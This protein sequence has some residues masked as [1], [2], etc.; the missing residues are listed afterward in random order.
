[1]DARRRKARA[2]RLTHSQFFANLRQR[3]EPGD[4]AFDDPSFGQDDEALGVVRTFD[5]FQADAGQRSLHS[6][7]KLGSADIPHRRRASAETDEGPQGR[8][9]QDAAVAVLNV[10]GV[11]DGV[12]QQALRVDV[13]YGVLAVDLLAR[14]IAMRDPCLSPSFLLLSRSALLKIAA[15]GVPRPFRL[16]AT[17]HVKCVMNAVDQRP[18]RSA[19]VDPSCSVERGR[20]ILVYRPPAARAQYR[21]QPVDDFPHIHVA[22]DAAAVRRRQSA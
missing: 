11:H 14:V 17:L 2:F 4:A 9:Q 8:D 16:L 6:R 3:F 7:L 12:H 21:H 10:G 22:L 19:Q 13:G 1:M 20:K 18:G 15:V 5:D